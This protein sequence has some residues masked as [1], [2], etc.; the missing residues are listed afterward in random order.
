LEQVQK[1]SKQP[2]S[3]LHIV[4]GGSQNQLLNQMTA[5]ATGLPAVAGPVEATVIG[6]ALVQLISLG[7]I[8]DLAQ[9][10]QIV[11]D[12]AELK[13]YEPEESAVWREAYARYQNLC[14]L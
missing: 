3:M 11:A 1:V 9:A 13:R 6:N 7:E 4:G 10:R 12:M 8:A 5:N 2:V 14:N